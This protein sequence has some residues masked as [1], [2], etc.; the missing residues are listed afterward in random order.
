MMLA[1]TGCG[2]ADTNASKPPEEKELD[3]RSADVTFRWIIKQ[4]AQVRHGAEVTSYEQSH[5]PLRKDNYN[6]NERLKNAWNRVMNAFVGHRVIWPVKVVEITAEAVE[7]EC[8]PKNV[9]ENH[10]EVGARFAQYPVGTQRYFD[11]RLIIGKNILYE[12]ALKLGR[13]AKLSVSGVIDRVEH[14]VDWPS[15]GYITIYIDQT[16]AVMP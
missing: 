4:A 3:Q 10:I 9:V 12:Q 6:A 16:K 8:I 11:G 14:S 7:I 2:G 1:L 5:N 15:D 13:G